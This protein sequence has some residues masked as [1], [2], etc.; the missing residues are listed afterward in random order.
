MVPGDLV[1]LV[2]LALFA[3]FAVLLFDDVI[4]PRDAELFDDD[5]LFEVLE[6]VLLPVGPFGSVEVGTDVPVIGSL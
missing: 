1:D 4:E 5:E 3:V 2:E 6:P